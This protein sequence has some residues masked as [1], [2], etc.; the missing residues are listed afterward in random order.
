MNLALALTLAPLALAITRSMA[1]E[2]V[3]LATSAA[4]SGSDIAR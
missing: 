4:F 2:G 3:N 1:G